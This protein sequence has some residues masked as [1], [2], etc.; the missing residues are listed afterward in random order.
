MVGFENNGTAIDNNYVGFGNSKLIPA[1][2]S[3]EANAKLWWA[4]D[5]QSTKGIEGVLIGIKSFIDTYPNAPNI[6]QV[7]LYAVWYQPAVQSGDF[8]IELAT[9]KGGKMI[10]DSNNQS[11]I[12]NVGGTPVLSATQ[13]LNT[14]IQN[15]NHNV[16]SAYKAGVLKYDKSLQQATIQFFNGWA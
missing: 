14:K 5:A 9:Y 11:N 12:I 8:K 10:R 6:I 2:T 15:Q 13:N 16:S 3:P 7:G 1:G 4:L